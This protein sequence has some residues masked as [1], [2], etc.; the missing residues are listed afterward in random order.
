MRLA[1]SIS[2]SPIDHA[3]VGERGGTGHGTAAER[4][5]EVPHGRDQP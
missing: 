3:D 1:F 4:A 5:A 2:R